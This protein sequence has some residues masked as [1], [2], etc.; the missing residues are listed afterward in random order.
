MRFI[1]DISLYSDF[2]NNLKD[3]KAN[4]ELHS[5]NYTKVIKCEEGI[6]TF[7]EKGER[8]TKE[9]ALINLVRQDAK[10]FIADGQ[11]DD[12]VLRKVE[13]KISWYEM[14]KKPKDGT[15][16]A[17]IDLNSAYWEQALKIG[18]ITDRTNDFFIQ[19]FKDLT[20]VELKK[21]R[22]RALGS[23][24]TVKRVYYYTEGELVQTIPFKQ[25][26]RDL[27]FLICSGIDNLLKRC[28]FENYDYCYY[29]YWDCVFVKGKYTKQVV[30]WFK[31]QNYDVKFDHDKIRNVKIAG[32]SYL[33]T[34]D[35]NKMYMVNKD[36]IK[37]L[38]SNNNKIVEFDSNSFHNF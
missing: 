8:K 6:Y 29:Y 1:F 38:E 26:T 34:V 25:P 33:L 4:F 35:S 28:I 16:I 22:L 13:R 10:K 17:K 11:F 32:S 37:M 5:T 23:L 7:N 20:G 30:D 24:A 18:L 3:A 14:V 15:T 36:Q 21:I 31:R 27:Y 19:N 12:E 9:L 2:L